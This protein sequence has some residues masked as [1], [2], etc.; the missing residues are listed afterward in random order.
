MTI[1]RK[2]L[3]AICSAVALLSPNYADAQGFFTLAAPPA[4]GVLPNNIGGLQL[5]LKADAGVF[6][7][8][9]VTPATNGATVQ[10]WND[11]SG[12][13]NNATQAT[14]ANRP[15]YQTG[16]PGFNSLP[17]ITF[18]GATPAT[19]SYLVNGYTGNPVTAFIVHVSSVPTNGLNTFPVY[20]LM[21]SGTSTGGAPNG[22]YAI[23][24]LSGQNTGTV[25]GNAGYALTSATTNFV[26]A[27]QPAV[28]VLDILGVQNGASASFNLM[29]QD[30]QGATTAFSGTP[31]TVSLPIIGN[32][33]SN[34]TGGTLYANGGFKGQIVE[35]VVY[36]RVLTA[37][38]Y[39]QVLTGLQN[40]WGIA[41]P[42]GLG[43]IYFVSMQAGGQNGQSTHLAPYFMQSADGITFQYRPIYL[44]NT[45]TNHPVR[46]IGML[47]AARSPNTGGLN[48]MASAPYNATV[49]DTSFDLWSSPD[50]KKWTFNQSISC[51]GYT[52]TGGSA[53]LANPSFFVDT[54]NSIHVFIAA[55][56]TAGVNTVL[57]LHPT[58]PGNL[59]G[60]W[61]SPVDVIGGTNAFW[62]TGGNG[63]NGPNVYKVG[64]TYYLNQTVGIISGTQSQPM[65]ASGSS[66]TGGY[67]KLKSGDWAGWTAAGGNFIEQ[68]TWIN[69]GSSWLTY[70]YNFGA[71]PN[72]N[73]TY[74]ATSSALP[75]TPSALTKIN[76]NML[77]GA[78]PWDGNAIQ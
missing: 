40:K 15:T 52:G 47:L 10:Q 65:I 77:N 41:Q 17:A 66:L 72:G 48:W 13:G 71:S 21:M 27:M 7:D 49:N 58:T 76:H 23:F 28:N 38:E 31:A 59:S 54:D 78:V 33:W 12:N 57:E 44:V 32:F 36:N 4:N 64:S 61:S 26:S 1:I 20:S 51:T 9:G 60:A 53:G 34:A 8:A 25:L 16:L 6:S 22:A 42:A 74:Y 70:V 19:G 39:S 68:Q 3:F 14:A 45:P 73:F 11:Q 55:N 2:L 24:S 18:N 75:G 62:N 50:L 56:N 29:R 43:S 5:W 37:L 63:G 69:L 67:S 30:I 46:D 35:I